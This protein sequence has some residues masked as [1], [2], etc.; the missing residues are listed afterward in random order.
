MKTSS[1]TKRP[2][3]DRL[4][5]FYNTHM[6]TIEVGIEKEHFVVHQSFLC[7]KSQYFFK[8]L[9]GSFQ[10][11][12]TRFIQLP[13]VSPIIFRIFVAWIY[14]DTL[15]YISSDTKTIDEDFE[16]LKLT[17]KDLEQKPMLH[18]E[19]QNRLSNKESDSEDSDD[20]MTRSSTG[21]TMPRASGHDRSST[22]GSTNKPLLPRAVPYK[23]DDPTTWNCDVLIRLYVFADR[24]DIRQLRA[25]SLDALVNINDDRADIQDPL[26]VRYIYQN[27]PAKSKLR[28]YTIHYTAYNHNFTPK[29]VHE[30]ET[31]PK[32]F[33]VAVMVLNSRRLPYKQCSDCYE[34]AAE[35][36]YEEDSM[37]GVPSKEADLPP[38]ERDMCYYHEHLDEDERDACHIGRREGSEDSVDSPESDN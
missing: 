37:S 11:G 10:E 20:N 36:W 7:A 13:D 4:K 19:P 17:E 2:S 18:S 34:E 27:T 21:T 35:Y 16:S 3:K 9:S 12:I 22:P 31:C 6:V 15:S 5:L 38:Y 28:E 32:E 23:E 1:T 8:A 33:L 30:W 14:H 26:Y 24:F 29:E 25:D